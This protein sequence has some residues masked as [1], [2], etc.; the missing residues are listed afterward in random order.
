MA[1]I[2]HPEISLKMYEQI[3]SYCFLE[4][5]YIY[6]K[7]ENREACLKNAV[8]NALAIEIPK[9]FKNEPKAIN[10]SI[11][12]EF[13]LPHRT[14]DLEN[15]TSNGVFGQEYEWLYGQMFEGDSQKVTNFMPPTD[16]V[17]QPTGW[18]PDPVF[19]YSLAVG[20]EIKMNN[21]LNDL[22]KDFAKARAFLSWQNDYLSTLLTP[23]MNFKYS[24][25]PKGKVKFHESLT[26]FF[27][28]T[29]GNI[30]ALNQLISSFNKSETDF[31]IEDPLIKDQLFI[32]RMLFK[33]LI[34]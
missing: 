22:L 20:I 4:S 3:F 5:V 26:F 18:I 6:Y 7:N 30:G 14:S 12:N 27:I 29:Y 16:I 9:W 17:I 24:H 13:S 33:Q 8:L 11:C 23:K 34:S 10:Q 15:L 25:I 21:N 19:G 2:G 31:I 32:A 1:K 28:G